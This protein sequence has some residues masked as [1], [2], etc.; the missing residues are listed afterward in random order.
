MQKEGLRQWA[1]PKGDGVRFYEDYVQ[2]LDREL[3][4]QQAKTDHCGRF[5]PAAHSSPIPPLPSLVFTLAATGT[6]LSISI[7]SSAEYRV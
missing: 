1:K 4:P 2:M 6:T 3:D 7:F 5:I